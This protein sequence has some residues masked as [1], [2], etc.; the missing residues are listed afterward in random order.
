MPTVQPGAHTIM[1]QPRREHL[2]S[3]ASELFNRLGYHQCGV[4]EIMRLS[5]VSKTTLYKHFP[6]KEDLILEVLR[7]RSGLFLEQVRTRIEVR[8]RRDPSAP[9]HALIGE[10][11]DILDEWIGGGS[12]FGCNFVKAATEYGN[13]EDPIHAHAVGHKSRV[14][15]IIIELL[16]EVPGPERDGVA[17]QI[18]IV[19]DGAITTAQVRGRDDAIHNARVIVAGILVRFRLT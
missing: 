4:D 16:R 2:V 13:A 17:E 6:S 8:R 19:I 1:V 12:F 3:T 7:R 18:M 11:F 5:G 9:H 14:K 10:I 15:A